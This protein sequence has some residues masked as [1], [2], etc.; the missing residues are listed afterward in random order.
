MFA[1][2]YRSWL[3]A[4][5]EAPYLQCWQQIADYFVSQRGAIGSCLHQTEP[6]YWLAYSRWPKQAIRDAAWPGEGSPSKSLPKTIQQAISTIR[7]CIDQ[8]RRFDDI[9]M[10]ILGYKESKTREEQGGFARIYRFCLAKDSQSVYQHHW[11]TISDYY[12]EHCGALAYALHK[13]QQGDYVVYARWP[14][15]TTYDA[16]RSA[17]LMAQN[18]LPDSICEAID[19]AKACKTYTCEAISMQVAN[20][21]S[22]E[23]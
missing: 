4:D 19:K 14:N 3:R 13:T 2:I 8:A 7:N 18:L 15:R 5:S 6:G 9:S 23:S 21:L 17:T 20:K 22:R 16:S 1:A 12:L 11:Q 10:D